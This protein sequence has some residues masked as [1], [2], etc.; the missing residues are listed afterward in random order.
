ML[1]IERKPGQGISLTGQIDERTRQ[2]AIS[3][4]PTAE[5]DI[6]TLQTLAELGRDI[7]RDP[8]IISVRDRVGKP[9]GF[10]LMLGLNI[11]KE[12]HKLI[13]CEWLDHVQS[14]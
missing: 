12:Q 10:R 2:H 4:L 8:L 6:T 11:G 7:V 5:L 3:N 13:K 1:I 9:G 14:R